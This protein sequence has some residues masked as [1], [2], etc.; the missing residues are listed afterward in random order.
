MGNKF[1]YSL[2]LTASLFA[3]ALPADG[4]TRK[5]KKRSST[6]VKKAVSKPAVPELAPGELP[7]IADA[8]VVMERYTGQLVYEKAADE[9]FFPASTTKIMTAL[10]VIESGNL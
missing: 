2:A 6:P 4:A 1:L 5:K 3:L 7:L 9:P 10:L 8:A